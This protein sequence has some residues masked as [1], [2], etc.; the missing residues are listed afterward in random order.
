MKPRAQECKHDQTEN[1]RSR[2]QENHTATGSSGAREHAWELGAVGSVG[3]T[4]YRDQLA[5]EVRAGT[6]AVGST[7]R[8]TAGFLAAPIETELKWPEHQWRANYDLSALRQRLGYGHC[9][10]DSQKRH[11]KLPGKATRE[12]KP[13]NTCS[14]SA[15]PHPPS[16]GTRRIY[17]NRVS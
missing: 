1:W 15:H 17:P 4:N 7:S 5:L 14:Q 12:Q 11:R 6:Q 9:C 3:S 10:S 8:V 16:Q 2:T 13:G